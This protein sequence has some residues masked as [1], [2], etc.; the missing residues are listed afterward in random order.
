MAGATDIGGGEGD[1]TEYSRRDEDV[2]FR[3]NGSPNI[4]LWP[5]VGAKEVGTEAGPLKVAILAPIIP[6]EFGGGDIG[7]LV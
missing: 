1:G 7:S 5:K 4:G 3:W 2:G 6:R